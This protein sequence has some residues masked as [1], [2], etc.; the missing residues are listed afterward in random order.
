MLC[1]NC[2][3]L[4]S[5]KETLC[6]SCGTPKSATSLPDYDIAY[7]DLKINIEPDFKEL[8]LIL[9][10]MKS[11]EDFLKIKD[12]MNSLIDK[13]IGE[14][15][16][17]E[18]AFDYYQAQR[19][20]LFYSFEKDIITREELKT[21]L[22]GCENIIITGL[23]AHT[24]LVNPAQGTLLACMLKEI[25]KT[26][27]L[28]DPKYIE[29]ACTAYKECM[30]ADSDLLTDDDSLNILLIQ[31]NKISNKHFLEFINSEDALNRMATEGLYQKLHLIFSDKCNIL[32]PGKP[33]PFSFDVFVCLD[34]LRRIDEIGY[35]HGFHSDT[36]AKHLAALEAK[37]MQTMFVIVL[38]IQIAK[39]NAAEMKAFKKVLRKEFA[40]HLDIDVA[41]TKRALLKEYKNLIR[42]EFAKCTYY[43][44]KNALKNALGSGCY[45]ATAVYGDYNSYEVLKL[46]E[47]RDNVLAKNVFGRAFIEFYYSV[48]PWLSVKM[49]HFKPANAI[50]KKI[51]DS[52]VM[53]LEKRGSK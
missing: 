13:Y 29:S 14:W 2:G 45:I 43:S 4:I 48:S 23:T 35:I 50:A 5:E 32:L 3:E 36:L 6:V 37:T 51:L 16:K 21:Y 8:R 33:A 1:N 46:R 7:I 18:N 42:N 52:I 30:G 31:N 53:R 10:E 15:Q 26:A 20:F 17:P 47:F 38:D 22:E 44:D 49:K 34:I 28:A 11:K 25:I 27:S 12:S 40:D 9:D 24:E 41:N 39:E 19:I